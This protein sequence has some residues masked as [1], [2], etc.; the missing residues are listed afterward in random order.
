MGRKHPAVA[1]ARRAL[2]ADGIQTRSAIL[3]A[4]T[5]LFAE[6]GF[7]ETGIRDI[8]ERADVNLTLVR[9]YFGSKEDLFRAALE[10]SMSMAHILPQDHGELGRHVMQVFY[11]GRQTPRHLSMMILSSSTP[12]ARA[13]ATELVHERVFKPLVQWLDSPDGEERAARIMLL[14]MGFQAYWHLLP[15]A[16][17]F[18]ERGLVIRHWLEKQTQA[19]VDEPV[20]VDRLPE[21]RPSGSARFARK[22]TAKPAHAKR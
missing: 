7:A 10:N 16:P 3:T 22:K 17:L 18:G 19:L 1:P 8:A 12:S 13:I 20:A 2:R 9:R 5:A 15:L 11:D 4:A 21:T 6:R 14:W